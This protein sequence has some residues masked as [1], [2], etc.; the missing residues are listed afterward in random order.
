MIFNFFNTG[1]WFTC[2]NCGN[3]FKRLTNL[4]GTPNCPL[5]KGTTHRN[6]LKELAEELN[7]RIGI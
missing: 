4:V 3:S 5:C 2:N 6:R 1:R 7:S